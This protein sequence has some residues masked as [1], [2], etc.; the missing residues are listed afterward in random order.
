MRPFKNNLTA[1]RLRELLDY[2][3]ETGIF[4][5]RV[6]RKSYGAKARPGAIAGAI[7]RNGYRAIGI[8][9]IRMYEHRLAFLY[10]KSHWPSCFVDHKDRNPAN[11]RIDNLR[12]ATR[13]Q[14]N[15]NSKLIS[16]NTSG[17]RGVSFYKGKFV[18]S[19]SKNGRNCYL[20]RFDTA[21]KAY[22]AY[23]KAARGL[24]GEFV[25]AA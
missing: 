3:P 5:W 24:H 21:D 23:L 10:I 17:F 14:N 22:A 9:G 11:N 20:G 4:R 1:E 7:Q 16:T 25:R 15:M 19:I 12:E 8:D 18:A 6:K 2:D 13:S